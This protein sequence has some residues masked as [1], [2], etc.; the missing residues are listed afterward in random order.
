MYRLSKN[1][2]NLEIAGPTINLRS[3]IKIHNKKTRKRQKYEK[4]LKN[5]LVR[6]VKLWRMLPKKVK[7]ATTKVQFKSLVKQICKT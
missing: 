1:N 7:K 6:G 2:I 5:P 4:H 3:N